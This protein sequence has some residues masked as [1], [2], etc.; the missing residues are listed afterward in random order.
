MAVAAL[1]DSGHR[2]VFEPKRSFFENVKTRE[3][4]EIYRRG[5]TFEVDFDL[6]PYATAPKIPPTGPSRGPSSSL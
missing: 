6:V 2:V 4:T 3:K 5:D 1:I